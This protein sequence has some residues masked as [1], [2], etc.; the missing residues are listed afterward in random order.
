MKKLLIILVFAVAGC[1]QGS[2]PLTSADVDAIKKN[3]E[4]FAQAISTKSADIG[5]GYADDV[6]S[7]PP[8][9]TSNVG[10]QKTVE[11]HSD[12]E[13]KVTS[14]VVASEEIE[15]TGDL[16]YSRGTWVSRES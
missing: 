5:N 7:M 15:G 9:N 11:F 14:F 1:Q 10:K 16:A 8:H 13:P 2:A 4:S 12:P 6:I 3:V